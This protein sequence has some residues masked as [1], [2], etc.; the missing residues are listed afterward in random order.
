MLNDKDP[1]ALASQILIPELSEDTETSSNLHYIQYLQHR[2]GPK[3]SSHLLQDYKE[4]RM[5]R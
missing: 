3:S 4:K 1:D 2:T 5:M